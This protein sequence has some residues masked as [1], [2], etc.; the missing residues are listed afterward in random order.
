MRGMKLG[1]RI[2]AC[3]L[4]FAM[5]A[6]MLAGCGGGTETGGSD[7][8]GAGAASGKEEQAQDGGQENGMGRYVEKTA[9]LGGSSL[10]DWNGR[11]FSMADG[12]LLLSDN[13]GFVLRSLDN[14][15]SWSKEDLPWLTKMKEEN[16]YIYTMAFGPD[17]TAAVIWTEPEEGA[18][19]A[20]TGYS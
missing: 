7:D 3:L 5:T 11:V 16:K 9:D 20:A 15:A 1:K 14:G 2:A 4:A 10:T 6:G 18:G 12:S 17:Q 13:S 8:S 19:T